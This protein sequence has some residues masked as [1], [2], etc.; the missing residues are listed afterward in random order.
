[1]GNAPSL[2]TGNPPESYDPLSA[3]HEVTREVTANPLSAK[4]VL[5][6]LADDSDCGEETNKEDGCEADRAEGGKADDGQRQGEKQR[7][8]LKGREQFMRV[9]VQIPPHLSRRLKA[10]TQRSHI[11][12]V[13]DRSGSMAGNP[14]NQVKQ[15]L[16]DIVSR[17]LC[18][19]EIVVDIVVYAAQAVV[20]KFTAQDYETK[21]NQLREG[22][23][24]SFVAAFKKVNEVIEQRRHDKVDSTVVMFMTDGADTVS[25][26]DTVKT[27]LGRW[28][29]KLTA[30]CKD[31]SVH[32]IGFTQGH[33]FRFLQ[34]LSGVGT[35]EGIFRYCE[36][37]DGPD[38]L[39]EKVEELFDF[40]V[41]S[42]SPAVEVMVEMD[43]EN[44]IIGPGKLL[45]VHSVQG[46]VIETEDEQ[47]AATG[48]MTVQAEMWVL[49]HD[50]NVTPAPFITLNKTVKVDGTSHTVSLPCLYEGVEKKVLADAASKT[51]WGLN[52]LARNADVLATKVATALHASKDVSKLQSRVTGLQTKL[53]QIR[54]FGRGINKDLRESMMASMKEIQAKVDT[55]HSMLARYSRGETASVSILARAH[56]LRYE[57]QFTKSRRQ[58][59]MDKRAVENVKRAK[60]DEAKLQHIAVNETEIARLSK[61]AVDFFFCALSQ[62]SVVDI[63]KD[64]ENGENAIGFGLAVTRPEHAV[65]DPTSVRLCLISGT[66]VSRTSMLDALEFK[67]NLAGHLQAHNGFKFFSS[68]MGYAT[69]GVGREPINAWLPLYVTPSHWERVKVILKPSLGYLCTLDPLGFDWRQ[70]DV[71]FMVLGAMIGQLS[72]VTV[73]THQLQLLFAYQR[74]CAACVEDFNLT[75]RISTTLRDFLRE[76]QHRFKHVVPNL[77]TLI[78]YIAAL[79]VSESRKILGYGIA[80]SENNLP[81]AL[82]YAFLAETLR[83]GGSVFK[84]YTDRELNT[85]VDLLLRGRNNSLMMPSAFAGKAQEASCSATSAATASTA[86][87]TAEATE[88]GATLGAE[89][90]DDKTT[91]SHTSTTSAHFTI[92]CNS[93]AKQE[94]ADLLISG[95]E[96]S[97][98]PLSA[99]SN[100]KKAEGEAAKPAFDFKHCSKLDFAMEV[101]A[102]AEVG[103]IRNKNQ[104]EKVSAAKKQVKLWVKEGRELAGLDDPDQAAKEAEEEKFD[105]EALDSS[106]LEITTKLLTRFSRTSYPPLS[107]IP[108][109]MAFLHDWLTAGQN[110]T[111]MTNGL[112]PSEWIDNTKAA[113]SQIYATMNGHVTQSQQ[114]VSSSGLDSGEVVVVEGKVESGGGPGNRRRGAPGK[115]GLTETA[116]DDDEDEDSDV[117]DYDHLMEDDPMQVLKR[118]QREQKGL[119]TLPMI[120]H[121][122]DSKE[123]KVKVIRAM[124]CQAVLYCTNTRAKDAATSDRLFDLK[125]KNNVERTLCNLHKQL[126]QMCRNSE[127]NHIL[128]DRANAHLLHAESVWAFIGYLMNTYKDR[129]E[130]F[131]QLLTQITS[132]ETGSSL[133]CLVDKVKVMLTG[134]W[135]GHTVLDRGNYLMPGKDMA[136]KLERVLGEEAWTGIDLELRGDLSIHVYRD[137]DIPNRHG[138]CNSNPHIPPALRLKLGLPPLSTKKASK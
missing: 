43:G 83:R 10:G 103:E 86:T 41:Y 75:D 25:N 138:H 54:L 39:R 104:A 51:M 90:S 113:V 5:E 84:G 125:E 15:A 107:A 117:E 71:L 105:C 129:D 9:E 62:D 17:S 55:M 132:L 21:I 59:M 137:S 95:I 13:A 82:W 120:L 58:R 69:V 20:V 47:S 34:E 48:E 38:K 98:E 87:A 109:A 7:E 100:D 81:A 40:A 16:L 1:M 122:L 12:L 35:K 70:L 115:A 136:K 126:V 64:T 31:V 32:T 94:D 110:T 78:G 80:D 124:L 19:N 45:Q 28:K 112:P 121:V 30:A 23:V 42:S 66:L 133:P 4:V 76:P 67:I 37:G 18:D 99:D 65:D 128:W 111:Q 11:I 88:A 73:G 97:G 8:D 61:E 134:R 14:W 57:A 101:W 49:V 50:L 3:L 123:N 89:Q 36:P 68:D 79:P 27:E 118:R 85:F 72:D 96:P 92:M 77:Y 44:K 114:Q 135:E 63:L 127:S 130:G 74:T 24:T 102:Q 119:V 29:T 108:G 46:D 56:D 60:A 116:A 106:I 22:G 53:S 52:L 131:G 2:A 93:M 91:S 6:R 26:K 33:D